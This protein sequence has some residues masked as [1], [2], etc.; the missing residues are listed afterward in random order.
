VR[1]LEGLMERSVILGSISAA[2]EEE[3]TA[4]TPAR[5]PE[6][7]SV[8]PDMRS[9]MDAYMRDVFTRTG[10][11]VRQTCDILKISRSTLWRRLRELGVFQNNT[12]VAK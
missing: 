5:Q 8:L 12:E 2:L 3:T 11:S 4:P 9:M 7:E 10:G 6:T 1:E